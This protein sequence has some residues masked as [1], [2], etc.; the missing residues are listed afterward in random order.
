MCS[1]N[2]CD[3][4]VMI[5][6]LLTRED[7]EYMDNE[8]LFFEALA[9][10]VFRRFPDARDRNNC[11]YCGKPGHI[12]S[13]CEKIRGRL[14]QRGY[15]PRARE[16]TPRDDCRGNY[17]RERAPVDNYRDRRSNTDRYDRYDRRSL[18]RY[19]L[20]RGKVTIDA[21]S[22]PGA[23]RARPRAVIMTARVIN[24]VGN[25]KSH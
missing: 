20:M 4:D 8:E 18:D 21:Q 7:N 11:F 10:K 6:V 13:R 2:A 14:R 1:V 9:M 16:L 12:W 19:G 5:D 25:L 24:P 3:V 23:L 17:D 15:Q 22:A